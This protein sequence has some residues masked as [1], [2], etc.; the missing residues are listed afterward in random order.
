MTQSFTSRA[1]GKR[2]FSGGFAAVVNSTHLERKQKERCAACHQDA[3]ERSFVYA[4]LLHKA[5]KHAAELL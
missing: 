3:P 2:F 4:P 1:V 5:N